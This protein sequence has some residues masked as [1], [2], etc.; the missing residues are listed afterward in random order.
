VTVETDTGAGRAAPLRGSVAVVTGA[1]RGIGRAICLAFAGAGADVVVAA[2][3]TDAEPSRLPGTIDAVAREIAAMGRRALALRTDVTDGGSVAALAS[4][5]LETFGHID[6]LVNNAAY[7]FRAPFRDTPPERW[8]RVL[9]VNLGGA[10]ICTRAF[11]PAM[12]ERGSGRIINISSSAASMALP[13]IVS[14]ATSKAA[15]EA[16][17]RGLAAELAGAGI[18]VNALR[19]DRAVATEGARFLNPDGDYADWATP[20]A[21]ASAA[22]WLALQDVSYTGRIVESS[23]VEAPQ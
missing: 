5:A 9:E 11:V 12:E 7:L 10:A 23:R 22:L 6:I 20:E 8:D 21:I 19:V 16:F 18:A 14:Y 2:R 3:S 4:R 15:L 13:D 1:S 17:S